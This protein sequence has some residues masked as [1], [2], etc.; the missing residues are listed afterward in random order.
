VFH[1]DVLVLEKMRSGCGR[2]W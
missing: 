1:N 2:K